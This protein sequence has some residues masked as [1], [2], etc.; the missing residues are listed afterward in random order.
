[1]VRQ[2]NTDIALNGTHLNLQ[3][4]MNGLGELH[5]Y[6]GRIQWAERFQNSM[7]HPQM[8]LVKQSFQPLSEDVL[9]QW[10]V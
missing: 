2:W 4:G 6:L 1:M 3:D 10:L 9:D 5:L 8:E 7:R